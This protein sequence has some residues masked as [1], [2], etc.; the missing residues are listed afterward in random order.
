MIISNIITELNCFNL[1][2]ALYL[3]KP[4][5]KDLFWISHDPLTGCSS[6]YVL[7]YS[8]ISFID[9]SIKGQLSFLQLDHIGSIFKYF[10]YSQN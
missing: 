6:S 3:F 1:F 8:T 4:F 5:V 9:W 10:V 7:N 2:I